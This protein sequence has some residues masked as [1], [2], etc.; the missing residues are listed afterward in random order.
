M[1]KQKVAGIARKVESLAY[2]YIGIFFISLGTSYFQEQS[3]Y[4]VPRI[5]IPIFNIL[6]NIGLAIGML[7]LGGGLIYY[8][9]TKWK[10]LTEKKTL[11]L[12]LAAIGL[13]AG[14]A[15]ANINFNSNKSKSAE[16]T[17]EMKERETQIDE[18]RNSGGLNFSNAEVDKHIADYDALYKRYEQSLKKQDKTAVNDCEEEFTKWGTK[19]ADIMQKLT[20]NEKVEFARYLSKLSIQ[21]H[22]LEMKYSK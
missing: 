15:L 9:F 16:I 8:G 17:D 2:G 10:S 19:T 14:I 11:Y 3:L 5:L 6:G 12:I 22:D 20:N 7:I 13:V 1:D 18:T 4:Q 21:W